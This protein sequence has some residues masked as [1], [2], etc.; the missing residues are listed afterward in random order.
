MTRRR[1]TARGGALI[2]GVALLAGACGTD[3]TDTPSAGTPPPSATVSTIVGVDPGAPAAD[4]TPPSGT[5]GI[6]Y[7]D[8]HLWIADYHGDQI[9]VAD[10]DDG[11][12]LTR[13]GADAGVTGG[14]DDLVTAPDGTVYWTAYDAGGVGHLTLD[15]RSRTIAALPAGTNPIA[16][17]T[18]GSLYVGLAVIAD[19]LYEVT[20][21]R[22]GDEEVEP[23]QIAEAVG[24]V[25]GFDVGPGGFIYGPAYGGEGSVVR[26]DP[27]DGS[28][29]TVAD[30]PGFPVAA[31]F[32]EDGKL[33]VL[34]N[35][36][37]ALY[38]VDLSTLPADDDPAADE[39]AR[40]EVATKAELELEVTDNFA[41]APDGTIYVTAFDVPT[42]LVL[43]TDGSTETLTIGDPG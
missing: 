18:D 12:I 35:L 16:W 23:R 15:G 19:G 31:R 32:A 26:I 10:A 9:V 11:T 17:S 3:T 13:F 28:T 29:E 40:A 34:A 25:N 6:Q 27:N 36:P 8:G 21:P 38:E 22:N 14:P 41:I 20:P 2:A 24:N 1:R 43:R 42:V 5:N 39:D 37:S 30:I 7:L 33:L 4:Q